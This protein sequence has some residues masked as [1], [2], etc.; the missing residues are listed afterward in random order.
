MKTGKVHLMVAMLG[1]ASIIE[2]SIWMSADDAYMVIEHMN[3]C[4]YI[5]DGHKYQ[6]EVLQKLTMR[7]KKHDSARSH[8]LYMF[9]MEI[10]KMYIDVAVTIHDIPFT[11]LL[12]SWRQD[13]SVKG[14]TE[15]LRQK[16]QTVTEPNVTELNVTE[17]TGDIKR[18]ET[19]YDAVKRWFVNNSR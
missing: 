19:S 18:H 14:V 6:F 11:E 2:D 17:P 10:V 9:D 7:A 12:E 15:K 4:M 16:R 13:A 1:A 5:Q 3:V 8:Y